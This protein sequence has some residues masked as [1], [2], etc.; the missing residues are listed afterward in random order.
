M[1]KF[2]R[3]LARGTQSDERALMYG[4][5]AIGVPFAYYVSCILRDSF[6]V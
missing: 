1:R 2:C 5:A 3:S 6:H 4:V